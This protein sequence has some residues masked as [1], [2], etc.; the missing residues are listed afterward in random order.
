MH[1]NGR[2]LRPDNS[3]RQQDSKHQP[4]YKDA[5]SVTRS[6]RRMDAS[7]TNSR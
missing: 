6:H 1:G 7:W 2:E 3:A 4:A 5:D